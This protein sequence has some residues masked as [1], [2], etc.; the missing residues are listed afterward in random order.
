[1]CAQEITKK[2]LVAATLLVAFLL[3]SAAGQLPPAPEAVFPWEALQDAPI[4]EYNQRICF[5]YPR[6]WQPAVWLRRPA[7]SLRAF[8]HVSAA[9]APT[10][11]MLSQMWRLRPASMGIISL[12]CGLLPAIMM[13]CHRYRWCVL[14][15]FD[16]PL[17]FAHC[18]LPNAW[19]CE[20]DALVVLNYGRILEGR[21]REHRLWSW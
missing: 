16:V 5:T 21:P 13:R 10:T 14:H 11:T 20:A 7:S 19:V 15:A 9:G 18:R 3:H 6:I 12:V 4:I 17:L 8:V 1:M 2:W